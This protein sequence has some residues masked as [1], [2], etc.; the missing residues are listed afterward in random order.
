VDLEDMI[1]LNQSQERIYM[2]W[3]SLII[4]RKD[5]IGI[6]PLGVKIGSDRISDFEYVLVFWP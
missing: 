4:T 2:V 6:S 1:K 5:K 3:L